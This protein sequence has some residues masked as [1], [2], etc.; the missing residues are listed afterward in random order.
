[1]DHSGSWSVRA[2]NREWL[3]RKLR[4]IVPFNRQQELTVT[5]RAGSGT[6]PATSLREGKKFP[7]AVDR[8]LALRQRHDGQWE[9][10]R[11]LSRRGVLSPRS[12]R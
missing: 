2:N 8:Q 5:G 10:R 6:R 3:T 4:Q 11:A 7:F 12:R 1:M 9:W